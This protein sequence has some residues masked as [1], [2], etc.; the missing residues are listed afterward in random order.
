MENEKSRIKF[1][2]LTIKHQY[3]IETKALCQ[4]ET[5][6]ILTEK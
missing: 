6:T 2:L 5:S 4:N 1:G 3:A